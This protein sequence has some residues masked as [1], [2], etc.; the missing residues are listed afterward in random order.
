MALMNCDS[1][2]PQF[3]LPP[4]TRLFSLEALQA[5]P[6]N[7]TSGVVPGCCEGV[8]EQEVGG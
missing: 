5:A 2:R 7:A 6:T 8:V 3:F 1:I 4:T